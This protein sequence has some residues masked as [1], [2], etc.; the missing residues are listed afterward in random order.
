MKGHYRKRP[1]G[2]RVWVKPYTVRLE[3]REMV[4]GGSI[5]LILPA[6]VF[7]VIGD[8]RSAASWGEISLI[9]LSV[10]SVI[11]LAVCMAI[12]SKENIKEFAGNLRIAI[13]RTLATIAALIGGRGRKWRATEWATDLA[14]TPAPVS[15]AFGLLR[16]S[17]RM[18]L[19]DVLGVLLIAVRWVL[20]TELRTWTPLTSLL[21]WGGLETTWGTGLGAAILA[22]VGAGAVFH[23]GVKWLRAYLGVEVQRRKKA[24][25]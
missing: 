20:T 18:R 9:T 1:V 6:Y 5:L 16:A 12:V 17:V 15:Y 10:I 11:T 22:V 23:E 19:S 3:R 4:L 24:V 25:E 21:V 13:P 8:L 7:F 2:G 14:E